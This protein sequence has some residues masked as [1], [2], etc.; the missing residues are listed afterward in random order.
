MARELEKDS[1]SN[2]YTKTLFVRTLGQQNTRN[3]HF[4]GSCGCGEDV[5]ILNEHS[6][7]KGRRYTDA[8]G[9][10]LFS[11]I[12][13]LKHDDPASCLRN[14]RP[15]IS[16]VRTFTIGCDNSGNTCRGLLAVSVEAKSLYVAYRDSASH[17]QFAAEILNGFGAQFGAWEKFEDPEA[18]VISYFHH[19]FYR[20]FIGSGMK[21]HFEEL[22]KKYVN[23]RVW[24][25]G[26]SLGGSLASMTALYLARKEIVDKKLLRLITFG[27]PR[28]GNVA[29]AEAVEKYVKFRYRVVKGDDFMTSIPRSV[30]PQTTLTGTLY[31]RQPLFY[32]YLVHYDNKMEKG[33]TFRICGLSDDYGCRNTHRSFSIAD[34]L[35][36]FHINREKFLQQGCPRSQLLKETIRKKIDLHFPS[37]KRKM[38]LFHFSRFNSVVHCRYC[39]QFTKTALLCNCTH[40]QVQTLCSM[41]IHLRASVVNT[42]GAPH[43]P[44]DLTYQCIGTFASITSRITA[45]A[46]TSLLGNVFYVGGRAQVCR[47]RKDSLFVQ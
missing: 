14:V 12:L 46:I 20:T 36:Y 2:C 25:T 30:D 37:E 16:Y 13:A 1:V 43:E 33:D 9:R 7:A 35:S 5:K 40:Q 29:F 8:L 31:R 47:R 21:A 28:T 38:T 4:S 18:G 45:F 10:S 11:I 24:V 27:E 15:D 19:A 26:Y 39:S 22:Q 23:Y 17:K 44:L 42:A 6:N 41:A 34:H 3:A 32:R